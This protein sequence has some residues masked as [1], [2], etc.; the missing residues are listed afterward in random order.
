MVCGSRPR[1]ILPFPTTLPFPAQSASVWDRVK[2]MGCFAMHS[3]SLPDRSIP[4]QGRR[5][6]S[7]SGNERSM[8]PEVSSNNRL[9]DRLGRNDALGTLGDAVQPLVLDPHAAGQTSRRRDRGFDGRV[10][11]LQHGGVS[12]RRAFLWS[13]DR[14]EAHG[15]GDRTAAGLCCGSR[16][17]NA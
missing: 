11:R 1:R 9:V 8:N 3:G 13:G 12:W 6:R 7:L 10:R 14:D 17:S 15:A 5:E 2:I 4:Q 16:R